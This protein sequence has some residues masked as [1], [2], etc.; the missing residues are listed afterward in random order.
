CSP[1]TVDRSAM[2]RPS[3]PSLSASPCVAV[4]SMAVSAS[5]R[6]PGTR[7]KPSVSSTPPDILPVWRNWPYP[8]SAASVAPRYKRGVR[9]APCF[10]GIALHIRGEPNPLMAAT[11]EQVGNQEGIMRIAGL[12]GLAAVML[13]IIVT[14]AP[15]ATVMTNEVSSEVYGIAFFAMQA[16]MQTVA[17]R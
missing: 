3:P 16:P 14:V 9:P 12:M 5:A 17:A 6:L 2:R 1:T 8:R 7:Q 15:K 4:S 11:N 13:A 10:V